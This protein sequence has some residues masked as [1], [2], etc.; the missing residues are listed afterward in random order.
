MLLF[1]KKMRLEHLINSLIPFSGKTDNK[2]LSFK[3]Q[4]Y[5][6]PYETKSNIK[7]LD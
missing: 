1:D 4:S 7:A 3:S 2:I 5:T 6:Y